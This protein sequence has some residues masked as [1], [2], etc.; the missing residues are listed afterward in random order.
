[1]SELERLKLLKENL[2]YKNLSEKSGINAETIKNGLRD[3]TIREEKTERVMKTVDEIVEEYV[4]E[5]Q[6]GYINDIYDQ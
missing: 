5:R 4:R 2:K 1:M 3:W 6:Q